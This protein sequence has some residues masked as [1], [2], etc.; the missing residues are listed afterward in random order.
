MGKNRSH[1][2]KYF[3]FIVEGGFLW[4]SSTDI[5]KGPIV[6][7]EGTSE[8]KMLLQQQILGKVVQEPLVD[9]CRSGRTR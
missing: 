1:E 7:W 6:D 3:G 4:E 2:R 8:H 5:N 9:C